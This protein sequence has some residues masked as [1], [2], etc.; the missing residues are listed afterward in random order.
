MTS[1]RALR[2]NLVV[3]G[4]IRRDRNQPSVEIGIGSDKDQ[5]RGFQ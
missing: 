2:A 3:N 5:S 1:K 4:S